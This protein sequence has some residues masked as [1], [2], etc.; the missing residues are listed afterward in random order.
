MD[1]R[2]EELANQCTEYVEGTLDGDIVVFNH[3]KFAKLIAQECMNLCDTV[4]NVAEVTNNGE[5]ARKTKAT[6][7]GCR[8]MIK[9]CFEIK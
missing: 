6:A 4:A 2:I 1:K 9:Q 3:K 7:V 5:M 8:D